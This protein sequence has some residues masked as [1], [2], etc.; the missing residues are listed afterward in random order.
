MTKMTKTKATFSQYS[1]LGVFSDLS[2]I[3]NIL[4]L[5]VM[6]IKAALLVALLKVSLS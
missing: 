6:E 1:N 3:L 2:L 5:L 4:I